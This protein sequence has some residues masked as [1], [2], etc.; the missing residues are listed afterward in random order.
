MW[1]EDEYQQAIPVL[2]AFL[3]STRLLGGIAA[4]TALLAG[5]G[6][7]WRGQGVACPLFVVGFLASLYGLWLV[8]RLQLDRAFFVLLA[9]GKVSPEVFDHSLTLLLGRDGLSGQPRTMASRWRG[10]RALIFRLFCALGGGVVCTAAGLLV[11]GW[12]V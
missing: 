5:A 12:S 8:W 11:S 6:S 2:T 3:R 4:L 7:L 9:T 1:D 10:V